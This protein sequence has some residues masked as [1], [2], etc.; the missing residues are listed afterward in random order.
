[1]SRQ[2]FLLAAS[3]ALIFCL[4]IQACKKNTSETVA[5]TYPAVQAA[6]GDNINLNNLENYAGQTVPG[7]ITKDNSGSNP[8]TNA[9]ATLGRVLFY[10]KA[11]SANNTIACGSCHKQAMAF[12]DDAI[13]SLGVNGVTTRHSMRLVNDRFAQEIAFFWDK[14]ATT[15]ENQTTQP[16]QNHNEMGF[17]GLNGDKDINFLIAKLQGIGYYK[18]LFKFVY[19]DSVVTQ[20]R[21]QTAIA[22]F[23]RSIQSFDSKF[24]DGMGVA[25]N[26]NTDFAN[27]TAQ[28]NLGK[29]LFLTPPAPPGA[30]AGGG[31]GCQ[32]CHR[33][34]EF[35]IDPNSHNNGV[36]TVAGSTTAI[37]IINTNPPSLRNVLN[38][39]GLSN[40][41]FM[42]D[43]SISTLGAVI[44]H[45]AHIVIDPANTNLDAKLA[46][47]GKGQVLTV[48]Q[49]QKDAVVAF[50]ATLSGKDVY[51]N[52]KWASPFK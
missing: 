13:Q 27:F 9:G 20:T 26:V 38:P 18:E 42:H 41:L 30:P 36:I 8:V 47:G 37:D 40:G 15:L 22:Q 34:P 6:F 7:Y 11:L 21:M 19:G 28:E 32:G 45:Y 2:L 24:D 23:I 35:D 51:T 10:D 50:L 4:A 49:A 29:Q 33:A 16:I 31:F 5:A 12:G 43:G 52:K 46:P 39:L 14:R 44:D 1:S 17:S 3:A 48:S 25:K